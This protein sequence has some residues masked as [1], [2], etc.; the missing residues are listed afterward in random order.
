[1]DLTV[2]KYLVGIAP[3]LGHGSRVAAEVSYRLGQRDPIGVFKRKVF[4]GKRAG[5][6]LAPQVGRVVAQSFL[7]SEGHHL[8]V[9]WEHDPGIMQPLNTSNRHQHPQRPVVLTRVTHGINM[10]T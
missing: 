1:M 8:H 5:E 3:V 10:R 6:S 9:E 2:A 4:I 7:V